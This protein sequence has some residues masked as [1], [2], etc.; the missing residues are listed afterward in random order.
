MQGK[1]LEVTCLYAQDGAQVRQVL[2]GQ[3]HTYLAGR[4]V[5]RGGDDRAGQGE[6][7]ALD[8]PSVP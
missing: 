7:G 6:R 1:E 5:Q 4:S 3:F 8:G 2:Q